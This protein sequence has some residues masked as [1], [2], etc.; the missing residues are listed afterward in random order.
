M[1]GY[2]PVG[3]RPVLMVS[4]SIFV[5]GAILS[6]LAPTM[7]GADRGKDG[8]GPGRRRPEGARI[9]VVRD[10][11]PPRERGKYQGYLSATF[12]TANIIGPVLG[13]FRR[14]LSWHWI[15]WINLPLGAAAFATTWHQLRRLP[16]PGKRP[17][18][19]GWAR[20]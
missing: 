13:G 3:R 12:A 16:L 11:L 15:F 8:A 17:A 10:I 4:V 2:R 7:P 5:I 14:I 6:A 9:A 1:D 19:T 20:C 18:S